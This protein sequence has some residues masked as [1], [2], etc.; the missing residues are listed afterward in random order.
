MANQRP[1]AWWDQPPKSVLGAG[2]AREREHLRAELAR[3]WQACARDAAEHAH[4]GAP[5][6]SQANA[7]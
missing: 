1:L 2:L 5:A 4:L 6:H 7:A 3:A